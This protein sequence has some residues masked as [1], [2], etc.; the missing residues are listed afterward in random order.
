L[1]AVDDQRL[2]GD[3]VGGRAGEEDDRAPEVVRCAEAAERDLLE[4]DVA[5][6]LE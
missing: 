6:A 2:S 5:G 3:E 4:E 1:A